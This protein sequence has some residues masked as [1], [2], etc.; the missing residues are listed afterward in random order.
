MD[1]QIIDLMRDQFKTLSEKI[2]DVHDAMKGHID[3]DEKYWA[4]ID[5]MRGQVSVWRMLTVPGI[6][7]FFAWLYNAFKH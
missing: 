5:Q 7:G 4:Q 1:E 3:K 2:D 6:S